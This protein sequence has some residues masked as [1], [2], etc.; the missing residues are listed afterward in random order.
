MPWFESLCPEESWRSR[1][2][3]GEGTCAVRDGQLYPFHGINQRV[4]HGRQIGFSCG[5]GHLRASAHVVCGQSLRR[6]INGRVHSV[7]LAGA[8]EDGSFQ[9][10]EPR[11]PYGTGNVFLVVVAGAE[12]FSGEI[13]RRRR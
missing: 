13:R 10:G 4:Q 5:G 7:G 1:A 6:E 9:R 2:R 12:A 3:G 8:P 11:E